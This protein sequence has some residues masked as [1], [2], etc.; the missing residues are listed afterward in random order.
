MKAPTASVQSA[1]DTAAGGCTRRLGAAH[2]I[3]R[4]ASEHARTDCSEYCC[5]AGDLRLLR[6]RTRSPSGCPGRSTRSDCRC[7]GKRFSDGRHAARGT[8]A[9]CCDSRRWCCSPHEGAT[10]VVRAKSAVLTGGLGN[11]VV[12]T[13]ETAGAATVSIL[14]IVAPLICLAGVIGIIV[15]AIRRLRRSRAH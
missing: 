4:V 1:L 11:P 8:V 3:I 6:P 7:F 15:W 13:A 5:R 12:S 2:R 14:A 9:D 10:A